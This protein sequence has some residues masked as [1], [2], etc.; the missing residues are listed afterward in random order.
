MFFN[1]GKPEKIDPILVTLIIG[2]YREQIP[3][4]GT[5]NPYQY[6][7]QLLTNFKEVARFIFAMR[8]EATGVEFSYQGTSIIITPLL[9]VEEEPDTGYKD[10]LG[11]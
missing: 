9:A 8:P 5:L 11:Y 4:L 3:T 7:D 10:S 6:F 1:L 2:E